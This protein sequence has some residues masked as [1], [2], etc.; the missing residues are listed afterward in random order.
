MTIAKG[1]VMLQG[2]KCNSTLS[3]LALLKISKAQALTS[4]EFMTEHATLYH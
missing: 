1:G 2:H 3:L 4:A